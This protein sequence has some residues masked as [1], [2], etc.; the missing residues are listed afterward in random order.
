MILILTIIVH[1]ELKRKGGLFNITAMPLAFLSW[2]IGNVLTTYSLYYGALFL[3]TISNVIQL[4]S[5][6]VAVAVTVNM[7]L[8]I[9]KNEH[10]VGRRNSSLDEFAFFS[11]MIPTL[12]YSPSISIWNYSTNNTNYASYSE[13]SFLIALVIHYLCGVILIGNCFLP[14]YLY[15]IRK[16]FRFLCFR[17]IRP[18]ASP[19][20]CI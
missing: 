18:N 15:L 6:I 11:Y 16:D 13:L 4:I 10:H 14:H 5:Y 3:A 12:I 17:C 9:G 7:A 8:I 20:G 2:A 19:V 1:E